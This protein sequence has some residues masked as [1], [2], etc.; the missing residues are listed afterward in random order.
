[1]LLA[2]GNRDEAL[3]LQPDDFD[4]QRSGGRSLGFGD[5][6]HAC[7]GAAIAIEIVAA[8]AVWIRAVSSP[9]ATQR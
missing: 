3:N 2:S 7:P 5:G 8:C 4:P 9:S 1:L 6:A